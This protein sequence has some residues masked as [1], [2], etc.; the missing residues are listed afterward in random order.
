MIVIIGLQLL[1]MHCGQETGLVNES[2][3]E[4]FRINLL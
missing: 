2:K 3:G 4:Y 1:D